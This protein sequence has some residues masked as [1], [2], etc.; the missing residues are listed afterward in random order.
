MM[1]KYSEYRMSKQHEM[2]KLASN[3][4]NVAQVEPFIE[5]VFKSYE[6]NPDMYGNI[7][8][9]LTEAVTN[10]IIHG[11]EKDE[12]KLVRIIMQRQQKYLAFRISDE[13]GGF[14]YESL[15]DPTSPENI[16]KIGGRGVFLMKQLSD[17]VVFSENGST[18]EIRFKI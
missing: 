3:P 5:Q 4:R 17:D 16:L 6:I 13:G 18:V 12:T 9:T 7:L 15:P 14:D 10:A 8:I 2:L 1:L 11:N